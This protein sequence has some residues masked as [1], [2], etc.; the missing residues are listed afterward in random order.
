MRAK[1]V[2][3]FSC[4]TQKFHSDGQEEEAREKTSTAANEGGMAVIGEAGHVTT[5]GQCHEECSQLC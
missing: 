2:E 4:F 3:R 1:T 5:D